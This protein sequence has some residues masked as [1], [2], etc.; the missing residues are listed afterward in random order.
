MKTEYAVAI[1]HKTLR[2]E[3]L[4]NDDVKLQKVDRDH[5]RG[6]QWWCT[7]LTFTRDEAGKVTGF[8]I[9]CDEGNVNNLRFLKV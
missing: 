8:K 2:L 4:H 3:H 6:S 1:R 9:T 7:S 5:F